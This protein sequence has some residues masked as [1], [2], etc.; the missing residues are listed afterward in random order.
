MRSKINA[1]QK[2]ECELHLATQ[3]VSLMTAS[4]VALMDDSTKRFG[5]LNNM[6]H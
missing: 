5:L 3:S 4:T 2:L 1:R 6:K